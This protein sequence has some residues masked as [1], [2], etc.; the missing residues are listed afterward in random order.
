MYTHHMQMYWCLSFCN[1][2][3]AFSRY[4]FDVQL[5]VQLF[6]IIQFY[7]LYSSQKT[8]RKKAHV[9]LPII[10][11]F[12]PFQK[13][14][15]QFSVWKKLEQILIQPLIYRSNRSLWRIKNP[16]LGNRP[17]QPHP[18]WLLWFNYFFDFDK[19]RWTQKNSKQKMH[20]E[21]KM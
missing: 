3:R 20:Q 13:N 14:T 2:P 18:T 21:A 4:F 15:L 5:H 8:D 10:C 16:L 19:I 11:G 7:L 9:T 6:R 17:S 12:S 1:H